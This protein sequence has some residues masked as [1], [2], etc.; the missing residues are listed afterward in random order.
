MTTYSQ[1]VIIV[2]SRS[3]FEIFFFFFFLFFFFF[4][5]F[6]FLAK[7]HFSKTKPKV[8][9]PKTIVLLVLF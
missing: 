8:S 7:G 3:V 6:F 9:D 5:F 1:R 2:L 4:F